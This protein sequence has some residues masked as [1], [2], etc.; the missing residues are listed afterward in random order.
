[1]KRIAPLLQLRITDA[2][3]PNEPWQDVPFND[4]FA[5]NYSDVP[6]QAGDFKAAYGVLTGAV[7]PELVAFTYSNGVVNQFRLEPK[8]KRV[9][10]R[11]EHGTA[12]QSFEPDTGVQI[13]QHS[14]I[15]DE[16]RT[17]FAGTFREGQK[18]TL[19]LEEVEDDAGS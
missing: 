11:N 6:Y 3:H 13:H 7:A 17:H 18:L 4:G 8:Q 19:Q 2:A 14:F 10:L 15:K 1:M 16:E 12:L 9:V 5:H